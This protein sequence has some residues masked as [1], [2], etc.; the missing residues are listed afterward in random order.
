MFKCFTKLKLKNELK[1]IKSKLEFLESELNDQKAT[2]TDK[3]YWEVLLKRL[4]EINK[5]N[6]NIGSEAMFEFYNDIYIEK[7]QCL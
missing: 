3:M 1:L 6:L 5:M 7:V 4:D 2:K